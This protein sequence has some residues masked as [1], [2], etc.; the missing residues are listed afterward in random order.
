MPKISLFGGYEEWNGGMGFEW[1][2][3]SPSDPILDIHGTGNGWAKETH[4][5]VRITGNGSRTVV[6][7]TGPRGWKITG[8]E[9]ISD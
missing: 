2:R 4:G 6:R 9:T 3:T 1:G 5:P 8:P 7:I